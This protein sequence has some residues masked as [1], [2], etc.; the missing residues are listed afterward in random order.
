LAT[1]TP[2]LNFTIVCNPV[3]PFIP[4]N[5]PMMAIEF[6]LS[7]EQRIV[8]KACALSS[9]GLKFIVFVYLIGRNTGSYISGTV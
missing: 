2:V 3:T 5:G 8:M 6:S 1:I 7:F 4:L 9:G